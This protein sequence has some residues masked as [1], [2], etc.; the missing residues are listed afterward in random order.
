MNIEQAQK[1][2]SYAYFGGATGV[3]VSGLVWCIAGTVALTMTHL[4]SMFTLFIGGMFIHPLAMLLSKLLNRPGN[5]DARNPLGK[6]ALEST[7]IL[8]VGL[9]IA[10]FVAKHQ[11]E[12][13][14]PIML[15]SI[16]VRYL[17][18]N[19][20]YGAKVYWLLGVIL[21][22]SGVLCI[23]LDANFAVG[24]FIGGITEV[25]VSLIIFTQSK[26]LALETT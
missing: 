17:I 8:F 1:D 7:V 9:F 19:T 25:L 14:Y 4:A 5:H 2:M 18:F 16:G 13:F 20:L 3:L 12:W 23:L 22:I 6:L 24:A 26:E 21:M 11:I 15:L 10:F